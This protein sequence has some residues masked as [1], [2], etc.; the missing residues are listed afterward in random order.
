[1]PNTVAPDAPELQRPDFD[2]IRQDAADALKRELDAIS[3][4]QE[5]RARAHELLRQVGDELAIVRPERDRLMVSLAIY[6]HPRAVH[7]AAG[8]ARAV[9][10]RAVRAALGLDDNT[11]APPAREWASIGRSKG[12]PFIPDAA[13]K[14]PKVAIRHA[15][16][17]GRRRVLRD[18]LFP[19]DIV[20]LDRLDAKAIREEAAAAVEEELN[21]IKDPAARLEAASRIARDADAA[22]VVVAR[23]RDR[24]A[25]SLEFYTRTRAVDKAMGVAR[26][27][28]DELRRVALGLDRKTGRLPS[29]EEKR[30]AAEAA[31][32][33]FVEDAAKRLPD[34]ARKAAAARARHLTAAAIRNKTAAELDG[35][36]GWDMRKI[37]DTTGLHI[38]SIRAKVRAVQKKA[39][40]KQA[41]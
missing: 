25:L 16:L 27:A 1:M 29:E 10:L 8:C 23:E 19:G 2:K 26:N 32:I 28:F 14:L 38:D 6:Q 11:P 13:A 5:R 39:A 18:I 7:E 4:M 17:T 37:A 30:A 3:S 35:K 33:D 24:C 41:P 21:A 12:V 15:E 34:L 31:D 20:K 22:H 36:P 40:Q 9:Q